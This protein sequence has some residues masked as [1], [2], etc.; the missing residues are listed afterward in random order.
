MEPP[1]SVLFIINRADTLICTYCF[2][3]IHIKSRVITINKYV[4][5]AEIY[6]Q[7]KIPGSGKIIYSFG[8]NTVTANRL[9]QSVVSNRCI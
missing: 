2:A 4:R 8:I 9:L 3:S 7:L 6:N 1:G 5:F